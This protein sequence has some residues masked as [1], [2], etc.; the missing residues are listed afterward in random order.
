MEN[1]L[2]SSSFR[3]CFASAK[4]INV[5]EKQSFYLHLFEINNNLKKNVYNITTFDPF[6]A[7][8]SSHFFLIVIF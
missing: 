5:I 8:K 2:L 3:C 7:N 4:L 1:F 6:Y